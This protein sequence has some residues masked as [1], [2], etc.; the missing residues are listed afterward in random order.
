[1]KTKLLSLL[2]LYFSLSVMGQ[3][4]IPGTEQVITSPDGNYRFVFYQHDY[5]E[6]KSR[7]CYTIDYK[8]MPVVEESELG[9]EIQ[10]QLFESAL[11]VPNDTCQIWW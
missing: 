2:F 6:D 7:M 3:T 11:G 8:G 4:I 1:M 9:V 5:G 10:N